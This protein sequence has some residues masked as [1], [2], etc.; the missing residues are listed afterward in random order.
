MELLGPT[1]NM[2]INE[3]LPVPSLPRL[4]VFFLL[5]ILTLGMLDLG[6]ERW[7]APIPAA[8]L[9]A[10]VFVVMVVTSADTNITKSA[11]LG[12]VPGRSVLLEFSWKSAKAAALNL[13]SWW[14]ERYL[15][16]GN[17]GVS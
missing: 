7:R 5:A 3:I 10:M 8:L 9:H 13:Y 4:L 11:W 16:C 6:F 15:A 17:L 14:F 12:T 1:L 2:S